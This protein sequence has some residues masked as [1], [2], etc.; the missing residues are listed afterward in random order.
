MQRIDLSETSRSEMNS[1]LQALAKSTN[2]T[3]WRVLN[4]SGQHALAAGLDV[5]I[6]VEIAGH[7]GYYCAGMNQEATIG[8]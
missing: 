2:E 3:Y 5:P 8:P 1:R 6:T 7:A 4:P